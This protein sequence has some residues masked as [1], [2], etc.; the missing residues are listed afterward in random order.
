MP[1]KSKDK[2]TSDTV[3][4]KAAKILGKAEAPKVVL[5]LAGS[6]LAQ[7]AGKPKRKK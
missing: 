4:K 1:K 6:V 3:A 7:A 2:V 5:T